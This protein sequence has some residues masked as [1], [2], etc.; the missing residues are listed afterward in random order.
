M[1]QRHMHHMTIV[2]SVVALE[3][4][5]DFHMYR[6]FVSINATELLSKLLLRKTKPHDWVDSEDGP[7]EPPGDAAESGHV[8]CLARYFQ[9]TTSTGRH[10]PFSLWPSQALCHLTQGAPVAY[11]SFDVLLPERMKGLIGGVVIGSGGGI[12]KLPSLSVNQNAKAPEWHE[13]CDHFG[14]VRLPEG[15]WTLDQGL[16]P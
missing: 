11:E 2:A 15:K 13:L 6:I 4:R 9:F 12:V 1:G 14:T 5:G 10:A 3:P 8:S 16:R 7:W